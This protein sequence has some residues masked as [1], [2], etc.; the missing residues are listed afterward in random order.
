MHN[1]VF[2]AFLMKNLHQSSINGAFDFISVSIGTH[3][4]LLHFWKQAVQLL[5]KILSVPLPQRQ[6]HSVADNPVDLCLPAHLQNSHKIL[7][8]II[9]KRQNRRQPYN[10]WDI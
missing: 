4:P 5:I 10:G 3:I 2:L 9:D 1:T 6:S 8:R 7:L